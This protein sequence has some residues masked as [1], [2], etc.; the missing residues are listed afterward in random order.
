M[1]SPIISITIKNNLFF[2]RDFDQKKCGIVVKK[3]HSEGF[4][5]GLWMSK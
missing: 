3:W 1:V 5:D 2:D 4:S